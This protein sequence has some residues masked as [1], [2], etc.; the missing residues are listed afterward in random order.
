M[1]RDVAETVEEYLSDDPTRWGKLASDIQWRRL[2]LL[3]LREILVE[4]RK[5]NLR[6]LGQAGTTEQEPRAD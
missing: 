5:L 4:L 3:L 1:A 6:A 2:Q